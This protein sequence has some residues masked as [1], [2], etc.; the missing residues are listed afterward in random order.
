M[1]GVVSAGCPNWTTPHE[2][3]EGN[4]KMPLYMDRHDGEKLTPEAVAEG[5]AAD[6]KLQDKHDCKFSYSESIMR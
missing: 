2:A 4:A 6:L 3:W 5:H 1:V